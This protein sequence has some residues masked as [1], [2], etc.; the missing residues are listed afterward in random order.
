[1]KQTVNF[2]MDSQTRLNVHETFI[3]G[4]GAHGSYLRLIEIVCLRDRDRISL[5]ISR[6][7]MRIHQLLLSLKIITY[8]II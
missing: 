2:P 5:L 8:Q 6:K 1:M 7:F 3:L 4:S